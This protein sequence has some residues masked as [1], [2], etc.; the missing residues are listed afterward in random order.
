MAA[1]QW[2]LSCAFCSVGPALGG[3][4][5]QPQQLHIDVDKHVKTCFDKAHAGAS[6]FY[7]PRDSSGRATGSIGCLKGSLPPALYDNRK[8][9]KPGDFPKPNPSGKNMKASAH[10]IARILGGSARDK[11]NLVT[12]NQQ[13][14]NEMY[15]NVEKYIKLLTTDETVF[16]AV[17]PIYQTDA[18]TA[19]HI[20]WQGSES[21]YDEAFVYDTATP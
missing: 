10:L 2:P 18:P 7:Y 4:T 15:Q 13:R 3:D 20:Q 21:G 14:N 11:R 16:Y 8:P 17:T 19:L 1:T 9:A 12:L 5:P 6:I